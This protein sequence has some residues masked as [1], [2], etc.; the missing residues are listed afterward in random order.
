[1][2]LLKLS[3]LTLFTLSA[4]M[5]SAATDTWLGNTSAWTT[6]S[7]WSGTLVPANGDTL[8]FPTSAT[9]FSVNYTGITT[10]DNTF[11]SITIT[12]ATTPYTFTHT[13]GSVITFFNG[14][15]PATLTNNGI[16]GNSI[17]GLVA[18]NS[19]LSITQNAPTF[20]IP[21]LI[22]G[23]GSL[24]LNAPVSTNSLT[25]SGSN[26]YT[27]GTIVNSGTLI[28]T[29]D[30]NLG[31]GSSTL[32]LESGAILQALGTSS[33]STHPIILAGAAT[34][35]TN[36][37][38]FTISSGISGSGPLIKSDV[39]K[40]TLSGNNSY[41]GGTHVLAGILAITTD[42][43]V[44]TGTLTLDGGTT[45]QANGATTLNTVPIL[46]EGAVNFDSNGNPF[47][48]N[49]VISGLGL[50]NK[51]NAGTLTLTNTNT[52]NLGTQVSG[53]TLAISSDANIGTGTLSLFNGTT[54]RANGTTTLSTDPIVLNGVVNF[55]SAGNSF[56]VNS[57]ISGPGSL[58][59][60]GLGTLFLNGADVY[61]GNTLVS[62]G[63]LSV[64]GFLSPQ[65]TSH[66]TVAN[67]AI[68]SGTGTINAPV[69]NYGS[70][71]PG[72][73]I[74][75][76][77]VTAPFIFLPGSNY[78]VEI[79]PTGSSDLLNAFGAGVAIEPGTA[80]IVAPEPGSYPTNG[81]NIYTIIQTSGGVT[82]RFSSIIDP[83]PVQ[84]RVAYLGDTV[85]LILSLDAFE[86]MIGTSGNAGAVAVCLDNVPPMPG[87]D[88][89]NAIIQLLLIDS[90]EELRHAL[91]Q[92]Q[93]SLFKGF[94]L[95]QENMSIRIRSA[96]T[97]RFDFLHANACLRNSMGGE[98]CTTPAKV[99]AVVNNVPSYIAERGNSKATPDCVETESL[100]EW[101]LWGDSIGDISHQNNQGH[102]VGFKTFSGAGIAGAD[103]QVVRNFYVGASGAYSYSNIDWHDQRGNGDIQSVYGSLYG[104]YYVSKFFV[105]TSITGAYNS[106][107]GKRHIKYGDIDRNAR[108]THGGGEC[109]AYLGA[110]GVFQF[111]NC[112]LSPFASTDYVFL[113]Q[114][115]FKEHGASSLDLKVQSSNSDYLRGEVGFN[116][117]GC[118]TRSHS[119]WVPNVKFGVIREWRFRGDSYK[120]EI[121]GAGCHFKVSGL[122]PDRTLF[123]P[124]LSLTT[125]LCHDHLGLSAAYNGEFGW[126][127]WDQN[128]SLQ[129][130]YSF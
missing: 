99:K 29:N 121:T 33:I 49:S 97:Q 8:I 23:S 27:G 55:D 44:G 91:V 15:P 3:A 107:F 116:F 17:A 61:E 86:T 13:D 124:G 109:A 114:R 18:L 53:G 1:M 43:N 25:L 93:P 50:L 6:P 122:N 12:S 126:H 36:N 81:K 64:N 31:G 77:T 127:F 105:N 63:N 80:L 39:G 56:T 118:F 90:G 62:A 119:K 35:N 74:G 7:N 24:T 47:T 14:S 73:S 67:G 95:A 38:S 108:S 71:Q 87:A 16:A 22:S 110:G 26:S 112:A 11:P 51:I 52:Y 120:T 58:T 42:S 115:G 48:I 117:N 94:A 96:F 4:H 32:T 65:P 45:L 5:L 129:L 84:T 113:H 69:F 128:I 60:I 78:T 76:L 102:E 88:I 30:V 2:N 20:L 92:L 125:L 85:D 28:M 21:A 72:N 59:K 104:T 41:T 57:V 37:N 100:R 75:T 103:Y 54:L 101:T 130:D 70:L 46:L 10:G 34:I 83:L 98:Q 82:G 19:N 79:S 68:L 66:V 89:D 9:N 111:G 123:A 40:L 106:Y